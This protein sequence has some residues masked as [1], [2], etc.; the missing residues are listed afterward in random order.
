MDGDKMANTTQ[1]MHML[2]WNMPPKTQAEGISLAKNLTTVAPF[3]QPLTPAY[4]KNVWGNCALI[5]A[6]KSDEELRPYLAELMEWLQDMNWPGAFCI[7]D[8]LRKFSDVND[9]RSAVN[10]C[11]G[12]ARCCEDSVWESN[13]KFL[14]QKLNDK[15][16]E[17]VR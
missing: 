6:E 10:D 8:R 3:I 12:K 1:I 5:I 9:V 14:L 2:D 15:P 7:Q 16:T 13:L 4:N 17:I 11:I